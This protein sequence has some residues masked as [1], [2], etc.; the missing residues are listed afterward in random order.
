MEGPLMALVLITPATGACV[1]LDE[2]KMHLKISTSDTSEDTLLGGML[3]AA[4]YEAENK[5]KRALMPQ[6]WELVLDAF[7]DGGIEIPR[8]PM[9]TASTDVV[10]TYLNSSGDTTTVNA[11]AVSIDCDTE[12]GWLIPSVNNEWPETYESANAVRVR[13][14]SGYPLST[15][16][17]A[18][19]STPELI[20]L[21]IKMRVGS[22]YEHRESLSIGQ[23]LQTMTELP[24][25]YV[26]GLLDPYL[27]I[28]L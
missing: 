23:G 18:T 10:I 24:R 27:V 3:L 8:P 28:T 11:T 12:P 16:T 22:M 17:A 5:T 14:K 2:I 21:W 26:D 4:Q 1:G 6:T 9:S 19:P 13:Y 7:P 25:N 15:S 20:K